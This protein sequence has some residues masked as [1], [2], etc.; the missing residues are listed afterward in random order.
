MQLENGIAMD[1]SDVHQALERLLEDVDRRPGIGLLGRVRRTAEGLALLAARPGLSD[2]SC[3]LRDLRRLPRGTFGHEYARW[4]TENGFRPSLGPP[5]R[6][7]SRPGHDPELRYLQ[8][9]IV[10]VHDLWH[11]LTGYNRDAAGELGLLAFTLGQTRSPRL[12]EALMRIAA[13]DVAASWRARRSPWSPLLRYLRRAHRSGRRARFLVPLAIE[14]DWILPLDAVRQRLRIEP[15][16]RPLGRG[17]LP[18][19]AVPS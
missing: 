15:L 17:A 13:R 5:I 8:E 9:R 16:E 4:M 10:Q 1:R 12:A 7:P 18:P 14:E 11:V 3:D 19:I 6:L 2:E